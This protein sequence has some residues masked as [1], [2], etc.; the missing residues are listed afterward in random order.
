MFFLC[1]CLYACYGSVS[2]QSNGNT[3]SV[4]VKSETFEFKSDFAQSARRI[5]RFIGNAV[6]ILKKINSD[7]T[8]EGEIVT[9]F[10]ESF[11][12]DVARAMHVSITTIPEK[13][14]EQSIVFSLGKKS[15]CPVINLVSRSREIPFM[16]GTLIVAPHS[17]TINIQSAS[18]ELA[19]L[20]CFW[21][22]LAK[23]NKGQAAQVGSR[24]NL[25]LEQHK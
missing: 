4:Q 25:R 22:R 17:I 7:D 23:A 11:R 2:A 13:M 5:N 3:V 10:S 6:F 24:I 19:D 16:N 8:V 12:K 18:K 21:E 20:F 14:E 15:K 1:L 9:V